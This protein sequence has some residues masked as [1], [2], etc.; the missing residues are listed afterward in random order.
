MYVGKVFPKDIV[1][2]RP[3]LVNSEFKFKQLWVSK[4]P[5]KEIKIKW[6]QVYSAPKVLL[7]QN[8]LRRDKP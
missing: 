5:G 6:V 7:L 1:P 2:C 4:P 8:L 3:V